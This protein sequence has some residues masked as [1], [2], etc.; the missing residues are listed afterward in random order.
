MPGPTLS[1][2]GYPARGGPC[3][4]K[5]YAMSSRLFSIGLVLS[6]FALLPA[7]ATAPK[8]C[9]A[10][11]DPFVRIQSLPID[12]DLNVLLAKIGA[13]VC[14]ATDIPKDLITFMWQNLDA[15]NWNGEKAEN[16]VVVDL[17]V[18]GFFTDERIG[19]LMESIGAA[20]EQHAGFPRK[21]IFIH[22]HVAEKGRVYIS[23]EIMRWD[24]DGP[25]E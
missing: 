20:L 9:L 15:A 4:E 14:E 16:I 1:F 23:G 17:Y 19:K 2:S 11:D 18:A 24:E 13:D 21:F 7:C 8:P 5:E 12:K 10:C 3:N 22:T 25:T 6:A